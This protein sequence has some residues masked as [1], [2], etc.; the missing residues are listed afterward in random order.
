[1]IPAGMQGQI[2]A[3]VLV[4][5]L[6]GV[7]TPSA[8][9][10][11]RNQQEPILRAAIS[12]AS[13][14]YCLNPEEIQGKNERVGSMD[15]L[16]HLRVENVSER[17]VI[18]CSDCIEVGDEPALLSV[19][20]DG[21]PGDL[22]YGG[23]MND[24]VAPRDRRHDPKRPDRHYTILKPHQVFEGNYK[25]GILVS[26]DSPVTPRMNLRPGSY[27]LQADFGTWWPEATDTSKALRVKWKGYGDLYAD[28][29]FPDPVLVHV[30]IPATLLDCPLSN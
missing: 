15:V 30:E 1:M 20:P 8:R 3:L 28:P 4:S 16:L 17:T 14:G 9:Q 7:F 5:F 10:V 13:Q 6:F 2:G 22:R 27:F 21:R 25:T 18:L 23:M 19:L 24:G 29:L 26:Y 11:T 12:V